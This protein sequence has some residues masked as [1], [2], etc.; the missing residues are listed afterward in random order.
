MPERTRD[1]LALDAPRTILLTGAGGQVGFELARSLQGLG[2]VVACDRAALDL[3]DLARVRE[4]VRGIRPALVVNAAAYTAVDRAETDAEAAMLIN[5][6][7]PGVLAEEAARIG[8]PLVH[9]STDYVFDGRG[10]AAYTEEDEPNPQNEYGRSK[11]AGERAVAAA[12]GA[13]LIFR[14]SWVYGMRGKNFLLTMLRLGAEREALNVVNDQIGA[15]TWSNTIAVM[16]ANI[17]AQAIGAG[18]TD[19]ARCDEW[20]RERSGVYHLTA[21]GQTSWHG[22]AEAIFEVSALGTKPT[23]HAIPTSAYPTPAKRPSNSRLS[24]DK[25]ARAFGLCPPDWREALNLCVS[26]GVSPAG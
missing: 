6:A 16:T 10:N 9:Y 21:S 4:A 8:A 11:L 17:L 12:G 3:S 26:G 20:W 23:V 22:F 13:H 2:R 14:T 1:G 15:P 5:G 24:N 18:A 19:R 25:L 7:A